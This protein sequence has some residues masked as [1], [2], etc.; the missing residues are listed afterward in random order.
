MPRVLVVTIACVLTACHVPIAHFTVVGD[1]AGIVAPSDAPVE[2]VT[3]RSCR[4]WIL[5]VELGLPRIEEAVAD[6]LAR[7]GTTGVLRDADLVSVHPVYGPAGIHC[8]EITGTPQA[9]EA[10]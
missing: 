8:Y 9:V 6:A 4:W 1:A 5:G 10:R 7:A 3:G 2:R